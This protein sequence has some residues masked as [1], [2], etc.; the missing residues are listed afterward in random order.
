MDDS[1]II[2]L[3]QN[4][5]IL[6][7]ATLLYDIVWAKEVLFRRISNQIL[8]GLILGFVSILLMVT[9]WELTP[10]LVF[11]TRTVL[12]VN[13]GLFFGPIATLFAVLVGVAY[14]FSM[15]GAGVYMGIATIV[16]AA[17]TGLV[18]KYFRPNWR[19]KNYIADLVIVSITAHVLM[20]VSTVF[21]IGDQSRILTLQRMS[22]PVLTIYPFFTVLVGRLLIN[23]MENHRMRQEVAVSEARYESFI[24]KNSDMIFMKDHKRRYLVVN[25]MFCKELNRHRSELLGLNDEHIFDADTA[26]LHF[27]SDMNVLKNRE[28]ITFE[29]SFNNKITETVK[30]PINLT[31][32]KIGIGAIVRDVTMKHK[33]REMQEV[34]LY[35][36]RISLLDHDLKTFMEKIHFHMKKMIKADN[37]YIALYHKKENKYSF[38]YYVDE[39]ETIDGNEMESLDNSLT[40]Y[41]RI[42]GKGMLITHSVEEEIN[43]TYPLKGYGEYSPVWM[44]AP[45]MDSTLKEVIGVAA[46]QDYK[47]EKAFNEDDLMLFEIFANTIGIYIEKLTYVNK[48]KE[49]KEQAERSDRLKTAFLA[50]MSHEIRTPLNGIIG[51]SDILLSEI[52]DKDLNQYLSI[53]N[54][55]AHRLLFAINDVMDIA[56]IESGQLNV[57]KENFDLVSLMNEIF[58][59]F[60]KQTLSID[61][62]ISLPEKNYRDIYTDKIKLQ[63]VLINLINNAIKFTPSGFVEFGF[64]EEPESVLIFVKDSGIGISKENLTKIFERFTQVE[65]LNSRIPG[66]TGLG[67]AIVKEFTRLLEGEIWVESEL[68]Q[69]TQFFLRLR[70]DEPR[71]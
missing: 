65:D 45:L 49:A 41:I 17:A 66:G 59:F 4:V 3:L 31:N 60:Q 51:F 25:E 35:L 61:F 7:A 39:Y 26:R 14:R 47:D 29:H 63:Q 21:I 37:F 70:E 34:L 55:S 2:G 5:A 62:R 52:T 32:N 24:N 43:K 1:L 38:P 56:K 71:N 67:L 40:D 19:K 23:R 6:L 18:W 15:G 44:G 64:K 8:A 36:S 50:N 9:T 10:G 33:K 22:L 48:L 30:F 58:V 69:G 54:T 27:D 12:F 11:D 13:A 68:G 42:I 28:I 57:I 53:I 20:L 46:V 16:F